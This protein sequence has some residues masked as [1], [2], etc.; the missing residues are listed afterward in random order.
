AL[1]R[2][3]LAIRRLVEAVDDDGVVRRRALEPVAEVGLL[4]VIGEAPRIHHERP[5]VGGDL[6]VEQVVVAVAAVAERPAVEDEEALL[7]ERPPA[8]A[9]SAALQVVATVGEAGAATL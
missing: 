3:A 1:A 4:L 2:L 8:V 9:P 6:D 5:A 7:G